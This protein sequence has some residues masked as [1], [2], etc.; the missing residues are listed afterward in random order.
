M[1]GGE[2]VVVLFGKGGEEGGGRT[3]FSG[4]VRDE[5]DGDSGLLHMKDSSLALPS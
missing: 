5:E 4:D 3:Y 1:G 2:V